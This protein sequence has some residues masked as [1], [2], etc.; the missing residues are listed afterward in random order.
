MEFN[1]FTKYKLYENINKEKIKLIKKL[2]YMYLKESYKGNKVAYYYENIN[3]G[4]II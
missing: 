4:D 3:T 2:N 1:L